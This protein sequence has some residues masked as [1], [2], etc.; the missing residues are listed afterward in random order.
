MPN[1]ESPR[2]T[3]ICTPELAAK[4]DAEYRLRIQRGEKVS[5]SSIARERLCDSY[6]ILHEF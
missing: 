3:V 2:V 4:I 1:N 5:Y 6:C